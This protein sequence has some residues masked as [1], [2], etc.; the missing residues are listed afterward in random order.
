MKQKEIYVNGTKIN[1]EKNKKII[2]AIKRKLKAIGIDLDDDINFYRWHRLYQL[3]DNEL[4]LPH[5]NINKYRIR[6]NKKSVVVT[7]WY[8]WI[9]PSNF[10]QDEYNIKRRFRFFY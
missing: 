6:K 4:G 2:N 1:V 8:D 9:H 7:V 3:Y 5:I 10:C